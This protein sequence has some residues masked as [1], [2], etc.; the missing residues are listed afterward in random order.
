M[1]TVTDS[2][3]SLLDYVCLLFCVTD[4]VL[5]Y[6]SVTSSASVV[7]WLTLHSWT[8]KWI[9]AKSKVML[10]L[11]VSQPICLGI[12]HPS[13][14]YDQIFITVCKLQTCWCGTHSLTRGR[15]CRLPKSQSA[16]I[17]LLSACTIYIL[18]VIKCIY[19][20]QHIQGLCQSKLS[21]AHHN[22]SL[23]ATATTAV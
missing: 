19:Y 16:V 13:G 9:I 7:R 21:T 10:R 18:H 12:K 1:V 22:L 17:I 23:V 3:H 20:I 5:V 2:L 11:T 15:V 14:T 8:L 6:V 4:L